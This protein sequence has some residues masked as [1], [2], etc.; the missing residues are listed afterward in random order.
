MV[1]GRVGATEHPVDL[2]RHDKIV[3][4]QS[5]DLLRAQRDGRVAPAEADKIRVMAFGFGR[6]TYVS[7]AERFLKIA[8]AEGPFDAV[9]IIASELAVS[10]FKCS[11]SSCVSGAMPPRQ[12]VHFFGE[13][14]SV[15][16]WPSD[17]S[18]GVFIQAVQGITT[19]ELGPGR[20][21]PTC[22][23]CETTRS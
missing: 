15:M 20:P 5:L 10:R 13:S 19:P 4:V 1:I 16:S 11:A 9:A 8:E 12:G 3:L 2:A 18:L 22:A 17:D 21:N 6:V 7:K 14:F 23:Q